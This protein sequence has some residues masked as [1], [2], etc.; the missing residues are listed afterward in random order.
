MGNALGQLGSLTS[1]LDNAV[2]SGALT[3]KPAPVA[4]KFVG[5]KVDGVPEGKIT[6][7][8]RGVTQKDKGVSKSGQPIIVTRVVGWQ[9]GTTIIAP[10][11]IPLGAT[12]EEILSRCTFQRWAM[13][14]GRLVFGIDHSFNGI[15]LGKHVGFTPPQ[16]LPAVRVRLHCPAGCDAHFTWNIALSKAMQFEKQG[17]KQYSDLP[18]LKCRA[19]GVRLN[20][21][22]FSPSLLPKGKVK[23]DA[24][25]VT[26]AHAD[27]DSFV[28]AYHQDPPIIGAEHVFPRLWAVYDKNRTPDAGWRPCD[29]LAQEL[30]QRYAGYAKDI[31]PLESMVAAGERTLPTSFVIEA[32]QHMSFGWMT[33]AD[34]YKTGG[35][36]LEFRK[37]IIKAPLDVADPLV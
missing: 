36:G 37:S 16:I 29:K 23:E 17:K 14:P 6:A 9:S 31:R 24:G 12:K 34:T 33:E 21:T 35:T 30:Q 25:Y 27:L 13:S 22:T 11:D 4:M 10:D 3:L 18:R 28:E 26:T 19:C 20:K 1:V 15:R 2:S 8:V 5:F 7:D 32:S